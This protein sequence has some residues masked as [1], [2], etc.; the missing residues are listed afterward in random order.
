MSLK[1]AR[2]IMLV[3]DAGTKM[4][5]AVQNLLDQHSVDITTRQVAMRSA[6]REYEDA[7]T[8]LAQLS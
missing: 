3:L 8:F 1:E 7:V 5:H 4:K 6:I 2:R